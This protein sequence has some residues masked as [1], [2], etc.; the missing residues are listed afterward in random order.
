MCGCKKAKRDF[1]KAI[2]DKIKNKK[3]TSNFYKCLINHL[4]KK[5]FSIELYFLMKDLSDL[6]QMLMHNQ[7]FLISFRD[8]LVRCFY[9]DYEINVIEG[10]ICLKEFIPSF[11][12]ILF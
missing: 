7:D 5:E 12:I 2:D 9:G 10:G 11:P 3:I 6:Y 4:D 8:Y 1:Q